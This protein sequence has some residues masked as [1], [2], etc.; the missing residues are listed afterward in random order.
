[1]GSG[2]NGKS[3]FLNILRAMVGEKNV[4]GQSLQALVENRFAVADLYLKNANIFGDLS[5][6]TMQDTG[7]IKQLTG[8]DII[9]AE[10]KFKSSFAFRSYAK[11][12]A[13]CNDVPETPDHT[14]A[15]YRRPVLV[16]FPRNFEGV[17]EN[18]VLTEELCTPE[19]LKEFFKVCL[20]AFRD[21]LKANQWIR[22]QTIAEKRELYLGYSDS[23][24]AFCQAKLEYDPESEITVD[25]LQ[26]AYV[27]FCKAKNLIAKDERVFGMKLMRHFGHKV[28][29][30]RVRNEFERHYIYAGVCWKE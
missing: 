13:S 3:V 4:A 6:R 15:F 26:E 20:V 24:I 1:M 19:N 7:I 25:D 21:A 16:N 5:S 27:A 2:G 9:T 8:N 23:A 22:V 10:Q 28:W 11:I 29:K 30:K 17:K 14:D 12:I 18:R